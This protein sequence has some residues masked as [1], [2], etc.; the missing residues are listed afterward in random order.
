MSLIC[1]SILLLVYLIELLIA[2]QWMLLHFAL[3]KLNTVV[4]IAFSFSLIL[5][6]E[7]RP[8]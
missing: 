6:D 4:N 8:K 1:P 5:L 7:N 2:K 3:D